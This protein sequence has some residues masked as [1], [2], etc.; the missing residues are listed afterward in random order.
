MAV[1]VTE[2]ALNMCSRLAIAANQLMEAVETLNALKEEK[3]SAGLNLTAA[4]VEAALAASSLKHASGTNFN[5]VISSGA[6]LN[7]WLTTNFHDDI[8]DT[9]RS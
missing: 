4:A 5:N 6:A 2:K 1:D 9:V 7:T 8:F 3:E